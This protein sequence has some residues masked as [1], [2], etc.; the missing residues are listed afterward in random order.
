[1]DPVIRRISERPEGSLTAIFAGADGR[2]VLQVDVSE[3]T[4]YVDE[5]FLR[6]VVMMISDIGVAGVRLAIAR[7]SGRPTRVDRLLWREMT[8]RLRGSDTTLLD[9]VVV[10]EDA[11]WSAA[12]NRVAPVSHAA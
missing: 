1:M 5:L 10:G 7:A 9:V 3:G 8:T 12:A 11:W 6:H 2:V 4:A